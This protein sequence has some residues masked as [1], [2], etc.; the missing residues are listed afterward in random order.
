MV[1]HVP[2]EQGQ[3]GGHFP[4]EHQDLDLL[5][6]GPIVQGVCQDLGWSAR[7]ILNFSLRRSPISWQSPQSVGSSPP[8]EEGYGSPLWVWQIGTS[9]ECSPAYCSQCQCW[10]SMSAVKLG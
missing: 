7:S 5:V 4:A 3:M 9:S 6:E 8:T 1:G 2:A 10:G